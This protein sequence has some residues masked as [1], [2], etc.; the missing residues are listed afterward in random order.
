MKF[1]ATGNYPEGSLGKGDEGE[2]QFGVTRLPT[3]DVAIDFGKDVKWLAM[4]PETA[5][6]FGK[7]LMRH[8][9]AKKI[10]V[11]I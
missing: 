5:M 7:L 11:E 10:S 8:A 1:G 9:G 2:L 6:E 3:G 4:P